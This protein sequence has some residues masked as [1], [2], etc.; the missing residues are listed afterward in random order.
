MWLSAIAA[1]VNVVPGARAVTALPEYRSGSQAGSA[2]APPATQIWYA[3][4]RPGCRPVTD[5]WATSAAGEVGGPSGVQGACDSSRTRARRA[6]G[7][8]VRRTTFRPKPCAVG[9]KI[10]GAPSSSK[11]A[12][13]V[14]LASRPASAIGTP[15]SRSGGCNATRPQP[16][17]TARLAAANQKGRGGKRIDQLRDGGAHGSPPGR[18]GDKI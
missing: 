2:S 15:A 17:A 6:D 18:A 14:G 11:P 10:S 16:S 7:S 8:P 5:H 13:S 3:Y 12:A 9:V 4:R 1:N